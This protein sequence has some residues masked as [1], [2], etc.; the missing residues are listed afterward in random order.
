MARPKEF[1]PDAAVGAA[2]DVFWRQGYGGT[3]PADL[4][5]ATKL[6]KGSL[7]NTFGSK[8]GLFI[9]ALGRYGD[10]RIANLAA[11]LGKPGRVRERIQAAVERLTGAEARRGCMAVNTVAEREHVD[12]ATLAIARSLY[13]RMERTLEATIARGRRA[14]DLTATPEAADLASLLVA[15]IIG[16]TVIARMGGDAGR[17]KRVVRALMAL[18]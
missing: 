14:G 4:L 12:E 2:L 11:L 18:L 6:G 13:D 1:D 16:I 7:Y 9:R 17:G 5:A 8:Q 15:V 10:E 3:T